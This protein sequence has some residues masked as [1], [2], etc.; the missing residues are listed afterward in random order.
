MKG[1]L[2]GP[3][4]MQILFCMNTKGMKFIFI[5]EGVVSYRPEYSISKINSITCIVYTQNINNTI[6]PYIYK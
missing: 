3:E 2:P 5:K 6:I 4:L 1:I